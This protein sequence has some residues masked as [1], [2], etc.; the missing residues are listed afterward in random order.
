MAENCGGGEEIGSSSE[1]S[2]VPHLISSS[3]ASEDFPDSSEGAFTN[4]LSMT[5]VDLTPE[6]SVPLRRRVGS[7]DR[8]R[9]HQESG[10]GFSNS[11]SQKHGNVTSSE[12]DAHIFVSVIYL[13]FAAVQGM[14]E[15]AIPVWILTPSPLGGLGLTPSRSGIEMFSASLV[16]L[17]TTRFKPSRLVSQLPNKAPMRAFRI[18][19]G[20]ESV[21]LAALTLVSAK[22]S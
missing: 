1:A 19:V 21:L 4:Q 20:A 17:W 11:R 12:M 14:L 2:E 18:G 22:T 6:S 8:L 15:V 7:L 3:D 5:A 13:L 16:L 9:R 10:I